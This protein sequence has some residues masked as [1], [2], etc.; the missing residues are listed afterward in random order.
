[1][2]RLPLV[3]IGLIPII[4]I[5]SAFV[6]LAHAAVVDQAPAPTS[7][8]IG[9]TKSADPTSVRLGDTV[10][11]TMI[12]THTCPTVMPPMDLLFLVDVS[13]SMTKGDNSGRVVDP[14]GPDPGIDPLPTRPLG[15]TA[16]DDPNAPPPEPTRSDQPTPCP[17]RRPVL[18]V[19]ATNTPGGPIPGVPTPTRGTVPDP[20]TP[21]PPT[22]PTRGVPPTPGGSVGPTPG[23]S[24][25]PGSTP[26]GTI[27]DPG[28]PLEPPGTD[29]LIREV[30]SFLRQF[31]KEQAVID[32]AAQGR[33]RI[34]LVAYESRP[35][36]VSSL[37]SKLTRI[38]SGVARLA[39]LPHGTTNISLGFYRANQIMARGASTAQD[40]QRFIV[41]FSD[42]KFDQ[43][44]I[45]SLRLRKEIKHLTV[46]MGP[47][48]DNVQLGDIATELKYRFTQRDYRNV[49]D[50]LIGELTRARQLRL[51]RA[52]VQ[53]ELAPNMTYVNL[54]ATPPVTVTGQLLEWLFA[55]PGTP[56]TMTYRVEPLE[57]GRWPVSARADVNWTNSELI[58][59]TVA[60]PGVEVNV[61]GATST[62]TITPSPT[63][64]A[65]PPTA[66]ATNTVVPPTPTPRPKPLYMPRI[67]K[68]WP[69]VPKCEPKIQTVD[70]AVVIDTSDSMMQLTGAGRTKLDAAVEAGV[71]LVD[72]L[73]MDGG[74]DQVTAIGFN[75]S[76]TVAIGL[77]GD[78][79]S[80]RAALRT[81][82]S[83]QARGTK[84]NFAL[85]SALGELTKPAH[86]AGNTRVVVLMTDGQHEG[87]PDEVRS[88]ANAV[89][90]AGIALVTVGIGAADPALLRE[91][92]SSPALVFFSPD[93][94][95]L[96]E[97][98]R[99]I[100]D[101]IPCP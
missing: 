28:T 91:I 92:A 5:A 55:P 32:A 46:A 65:I 97:I 63:A 77:S 98:Y 20:R 19:P 22:T 13:N 57:A 95:G 53:D 94:E 27:I 54:S 24:V 18:P 39:N 12:M 100:A 48:P 33:L 96:A 76:P 67:I 83:T 51:T 15:P 68:N 90:A 7:C 10:Q 61:I 29:D 23:G 84:I 80:V 3:L 31:L 101:V 86:R 17:T 26:G 1:V 38:Q 40:A 59:G 44:S 47:S 85:T 75:S 8:Q 45:R 64:T 30:Q 58:T 9:L 78:R 42:G 4:L 73:K 60:F 16:T 35:H 14:C 82:P 87:T 49:A 66:T 34:S 74:G 81:L 41:L 50:L 37:T 2:R 88:A 79:G 11:V 89:K 36:T 43:R 56:V 25:P 72:N 93:A 21:Q 52:L 6:A 70:V 62:P 71:L 69:P 99:R